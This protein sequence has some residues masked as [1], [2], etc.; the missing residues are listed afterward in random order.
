MLTRHPYW[1]PIEAETIDMSDRQANWQ[2]VYSTKTED[3]VSWFQE[4]PS[5]SLE[6]IKLTEAKQNSAIID[7]GGGASR[8][9]DVLL[10]DGFRDL[11]VLDLSS[12]ALAAARTRIGADATVVD[13]I[14]ADVTAW[15]PGRQYDIWHDRAAFHFLVDPADQAAYVDRLRS[16]LRPAGHV[17]IGTFALDGPEKCSGL[18]VQRYDATRLQKVLGNGFILVEERNETHAT[19]WGSTQQFQFVIL[20]RA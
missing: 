7:I 20:R 12:A 17:I 11:T 13:W 3:Q 15:A 2:A 14:V 9:V 10:R 6:L 1:E 16:A 19:P 5:L 4:T 8:L 18:P